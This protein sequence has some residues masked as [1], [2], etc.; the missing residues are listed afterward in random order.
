[1]HNKFYS[2]PVFNKIE[3]KSYFHI[4]K[5]LQIMQKFS[6]AGFQQVPLI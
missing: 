6:D 1:M 4:V 5:W 3:K 2:V